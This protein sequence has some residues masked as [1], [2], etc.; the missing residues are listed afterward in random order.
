VTAA[1]QAKIY[2]TREL[3][4]MLNEHDRKHPSHRSNC[5]CGHGLIKAARDLFARTLPPPIPIQQPG[6]RPYVPPDVRRGT[7]KGVGRR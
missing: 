7:T 2:S 1:P 5:G 4:D 6:P 3:A